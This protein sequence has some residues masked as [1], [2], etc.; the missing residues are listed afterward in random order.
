MTSSCKGE[1][2]ACSCGM[3]G[4]RL[5]GFLPARLAWAARL[6]PAQALSGLTGT[7]SSPVDTVCTAEQAEGI[8]SLQAFH[9]PQANCEP[10]ASLAGARSQV[11]DRAQL[12]H[13]ADRQ[14]ASPG[15]AAGGPKL[16]GRSGPTSQRCP[17]HRLKVMMPFSRASAQ[18]QGGMR[19]CRATQNNQ[20]SV[21]RCPGWHERSTGTSR[22]E[23]AQRGQP[24][25]E[26]AGCQ[27]AVAPR[28]GHGAAGSGGPGACAAAGHPAA[29]CK[30]VAEPAGGA[31]GSWTVTPIV[32]QGLASSLPA[33]G[34]T[35]S[36]CA[37]LAWPGLGPY[38]SQRRPLHGRSTR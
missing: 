31:E 27:P 28:Q 22:Q 30:P 34:F 19:T 12:L 17:G 14:A 9:D 38:S 2:C 6:G 26:L 1:S 20:P 35:S 33:F 4:A 15:H 5:A 23:A 13:C 8:L 3:R 7:R 21:C 18:V 32:Q 16:R 36:P 25:A 10:P 37:G 29:D 24:Q 11:G